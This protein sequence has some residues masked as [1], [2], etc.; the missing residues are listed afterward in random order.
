MASAVD[1]ASVFKDLRS[2]L[3][4]HAPRLVVK[5]DNESNYYLNSAQLYQGKTLSTGF[6]TC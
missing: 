5:T 4:V 2:I 3:E 1:F 6:L